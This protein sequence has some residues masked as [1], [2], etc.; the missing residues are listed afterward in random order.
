ML[1]LSSIYKHAVICHTEKYEME[2][3]Y[4][5][6]F[7]Q[8]YNNVSKDYTLYAM[9]DSTESNIG[10]LDTCLFYDGYFVIDIPSCINKKGENNYEK[11]SKS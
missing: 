10:I 7:R 3:L 11:E 5:E 9:H 1:L 2:L 4:N 6:L 8:E